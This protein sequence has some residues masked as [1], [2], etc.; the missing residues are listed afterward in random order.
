MKMNNKKTPAKPAAK[1]VAAKPAVAKAPAKAAAKPQ[2]KPAAT[3]PAAK[4]A[5]AKP[6]VAPK[7]AP[8]PAA[9]PQPRAVAVERW[10]I[11]D[12]SEHSIEFNEKNGLAFDPAG[13]ICTPIGRAE[14]AWVGS[15]SDT[16]FANDGVG[17]QK[18]T[19]VFNQDDPEIEPFFNRIMAFQTAALEVLGV[20]PTDEIA[21]LKTDDKFDGAPHMVVTRKAKLDPADETGE[22]VIPVPH[23]NKS[24]QE[25]DEQCWSGDSV[26]VEFSLC[27]YNTP[28]ACG[29]KPYLS[30][31]QVIEEGPREGKGGKRGGTFRNE[32]GPVTGGSFAKPA[33][34]GKGKPVAAEV[35]DEE[36]QEGDGSEQ[37][38]DLPF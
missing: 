32:G 35:P 28:Q 29:V 4:A 17:K 5:P 14:Y 37:G 25:I 24:G 11:V 30:A 23:Y 2:A 22:G 31:V 12:Y 34:K 3:K 1:P 13:A 27:A 6:A 7:V 10:P 33:P 18:I 19:V 8:K 38:D 26:R 20:E 21:F 15:K 16:K 9:K 36:T